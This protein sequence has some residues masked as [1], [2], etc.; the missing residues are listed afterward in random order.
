MQHTKNQCIL[1][2]GCLAFNNNTAQ[3]Y[4]F[5]CKR[6]HRAFNGDK[7]RA[8]DQ[9][10]DKVKA[11]ICAIR[12]QRMETIIRWNLYSEPPDKSEQLVFSIKVS[13]SSLILFYAS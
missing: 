8:F 2:L 5:K 6:G 1:T 4:V 12:I 11:S 3:L 10:L 9:R 13:S 7:I